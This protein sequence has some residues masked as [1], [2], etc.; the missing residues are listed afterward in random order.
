MPSTAEAKV[1]KRGGAKAYRTVR[2]ANGRTMLVAVVPKAG[3]KGG[4]TV[5]LAGPSQ[6]K[7]SPAGRRMSRK[8]LREIARRRKRRANG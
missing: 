1:A 4:H 3:P 8:R 2:L 5:A 7:P 6:V